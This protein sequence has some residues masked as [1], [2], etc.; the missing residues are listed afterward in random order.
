MCIGKF[1]SVASRNRRTA[2]MFH[3][4][5]PDRQGGNRLRRNGL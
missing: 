3:F 2:A 1:R 4:P 5:G